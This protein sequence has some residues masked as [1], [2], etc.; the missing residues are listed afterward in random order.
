MDNFTYNPEHYNINLYSHKILESHME[1]FFSV[2][3]YLYFYPPFN[4]GMVNK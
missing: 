2:L 1:Q 3:K 4:I